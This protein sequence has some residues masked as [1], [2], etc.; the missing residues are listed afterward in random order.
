[1]FLLSLGSHTERLGLEIRAGRTLYDSE[2]LHV[3]YQVLIGF[4]FWV[5]LFSVHLCGVSRDGEI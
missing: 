2:T 5:V 3:R 4:L 1:M